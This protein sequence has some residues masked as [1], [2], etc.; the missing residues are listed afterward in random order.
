M[1]KSSEL[2]MLLV[3]KYIN[4]IKHKIQSARTNNSEMNFTLHVCSLEQPSSRAYS[5]LILE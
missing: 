5:C 4:D 1:K 3:K 2:R